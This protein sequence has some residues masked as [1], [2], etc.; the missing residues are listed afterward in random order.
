[1]PYVT[2][3]KATGS[4]QSIFRDGL[5]RG[6]QEVRRADAGA[7]WSPSKNPIKSKVLATL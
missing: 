4:F 3:G 2:V 5:H 6:S 1:M 7:A